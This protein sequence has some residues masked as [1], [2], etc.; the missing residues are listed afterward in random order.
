MQK[1]RL[2][3]KETPRRQRKGNQK[4]ICPENQILNTLAKE[5]VIRLEKQNA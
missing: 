1:L 2:P 5:K 4:M 3:K